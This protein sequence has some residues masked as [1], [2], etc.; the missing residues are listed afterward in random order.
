MNYNSDQLV[1]LGIFALITGCR[2][3]I[4]IIRGVH[5]VL[6]L[7]NS[8][9][10]VERTVESLPVAGVGLGSLLVLRNIFTPDICSFLAY[11]LTMPAPLQRAGFLLALFS[12][13]LLVSGYWALG[14]SWRIGIGDEER[15][16]LITTGIFAYTRNPVYLFFFSFLAGLFLINGDYTLLFLYIVVSA[17]LH[18]Q[19]LREEKVLRR[20]FGEIYERYASQTPRYL[21]KLR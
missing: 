4:S 8:K 15:S 1:L 16:D 11:G 3:L 7:R 17:S 18:L 10:T 5:P 19:V 12:F 21:L 2:Y 20:Q 9:G 14:N 13:S 6:I